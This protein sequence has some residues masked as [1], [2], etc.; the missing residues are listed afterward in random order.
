MGAQMSRRQLLAAAGL[1]ASA[2]L[3]GC[4]SAGGGSSASSSAPTAGEKAPVLDE[5]ALRRKVASLL[6]VGFR[7]TSVA[8]GDWIVRAIREQGLGGV[9]LFDTDQLTGGPRNITSPA[10]VTSL[11]KSLRDAAP[12]PLIVSIDQEG[13]QI[14]RLNPG[15]GFPASQSQQQV[16]AVNTTANTASWAQGMVRSMK[17]IGV[18]MNFAPVVDLNV[19]PANP[20]IGELGRSFSADP[21]VVVA[22]AAEEIK[23]HRA[24]GIKTSIKHFPGFGSATGNTDF[25]VVDVTSTWK[26][27]ELVPFQRLIAD[28]NTDSVLVAHLLNRQLDPSRPMSLSP[29]V[30]TELLRGELG[31]AGPVVSDDMQAAGITGRYGDAEAFTLAV[32]AGVDLL[33]YANQQVYD[34]DIVRKTLDTAVKQ[35][36]AGQLTMAQ[37]DAAVKRV[38]TLRP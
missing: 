3:A 14:S 10:Q 19:N 17:S 21:N 16:G 28:G 35:V 5:A 11:V 33:V 20:A 26:R 18:T 24:A 27:S 30:V 13:G 37:I 9:I 15:D 1:A 8:P 34:P 12:G 38:D 2:A 7:G 6:V 4:G 31:W 32:Q 29:K 36:K 23:V 22:N 25:D